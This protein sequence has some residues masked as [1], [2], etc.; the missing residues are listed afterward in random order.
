M[1]DL[2]LYLFIYQDGSSG[3]SYQVGDDAMLL[4]D[5]IRDNWISSKT[6]YRREKISISKKAEQNK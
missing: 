3:I 2:K 4:K 6:Y 1:N 5:I